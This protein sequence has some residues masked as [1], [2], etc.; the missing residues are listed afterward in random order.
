MTST[1]TVPVGRGRHRRGR[2]GLRPVSSFVTVVR[3]GFFSA[4]FRPGKHRFEYPA[5]APRPAVR[6]AHAV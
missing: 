2:P 5:A 1:F 3:R 6:P 4:W